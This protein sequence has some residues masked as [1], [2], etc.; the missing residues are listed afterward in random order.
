MDS[1]SWL[2]LE[3]FILNVAFACDR[4]V[5]NK[6]ALL[7]LAKKVDKDFRYKVIIKGFPTKKEAYSM[8]FDFM[9]E[10]QTDIDVDSVV[11]D[12][13]LLASAHRN[14]ISYLFNFS[15]TNREAVNCH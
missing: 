6:D 9:S 15:V 4:D 13:M 7:F 10:T 11:N 2:S 3:S 5:S 1:K 8:A 14:S 12:F